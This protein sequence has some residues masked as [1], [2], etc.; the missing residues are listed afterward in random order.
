MPWC[1]FAADLER[2]E[3]WN[4]WITN[5]SLE[6]S[7]RWNFARAIDRAAST[8]G[9]EARGRRWHFISKCVSRL[10]CMSQLRIQITDEVACSHQRDHV[11]G[12]SI[13]GWITWCKLR[14]FPPSWPDV[15][16]RSSRVFVI[17]QKAAHTASIFIMLFFTFTQSVCLPPTCCLWGRSRG[18][19]RDAPCRRFPYLIIIKPPVTRPF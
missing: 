5:A 3:S 9:V 17:S 2:S 18:S 7:Q 16:F 19:F 14:T 12:I 11:I 1:P 10:Q 13:P 4:D 15:G 8:I 6:R